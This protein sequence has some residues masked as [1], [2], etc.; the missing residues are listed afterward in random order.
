MSIEKK[1]KCKECES[2]GWIESGTRRENGIEVPILVQCQCQRKD[3]DLIDEISDFIG[4]VVFD[5]PDTFRG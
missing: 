5:S 4:R 3:T 1:E 2:S